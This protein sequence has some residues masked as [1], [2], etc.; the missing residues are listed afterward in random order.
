MENNYNDN[1]IKIGNILHEAFSYEGEKPNKV[2][3]KV[4]EVLDDLGVTEFKPNGDISNPKIE[5]E[6]DK[7]GTVTGYKAHHITSDVLDKLMPWNMA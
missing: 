4:A 2:E 5:F 7:R 3:Y 1:V 6:K